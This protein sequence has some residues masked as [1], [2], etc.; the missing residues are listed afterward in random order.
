M[1]RLAVPAQGEGR[2]EDDVTSATEPLPGAPKLALALLDDAFEPAREGD[3]ET[4][5]L[6]LRRVLDLMVRSAS[7]PPSAWNDVHHVHARLQQVIDESAEKIRA[8]LGAA[9]G[10]RM[11][12]RRYGATAPLGTADE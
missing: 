9:G 7:L 6:I 8:Q 4:V 1:S 2:A 10:G 12:A 11:A 5:D 3:M